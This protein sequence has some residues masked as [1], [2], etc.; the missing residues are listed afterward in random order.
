MSAIGLGGSLSD[1][2][3]K[4]GEHEVGKRKLPSARRNEVT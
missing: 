2:S 3:G 4:E 1:A